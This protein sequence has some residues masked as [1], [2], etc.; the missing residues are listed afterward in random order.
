MSKIFVGNLPWSINNISL[1]ELFQRYGTIVDSVVVID[2]NTGRSRG[3]G[4]VTFESNESVN[5]ALT[6]NQQLVENRPITVSVAV[7]NPKKNNGRY[8]QFAK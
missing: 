7:E 4:F 5:D 8:K 1:G 3:F 2:K 6:M